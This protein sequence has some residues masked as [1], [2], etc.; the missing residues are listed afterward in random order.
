MLYL[1]AHTGRLTG[2]DEITLGGLGETE[3]A[4]ER[5]L[6]APDA[7]DGGDGGGGGD[8]RDGGQNGGGSTAP[9]SPGG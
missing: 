8:A 3:V 2:Y 6:V 5:T 4:I 7:G 9:T 1:G